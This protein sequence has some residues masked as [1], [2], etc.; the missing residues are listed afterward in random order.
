MLFDQIKS[1]LVTAMRARDALVT[2]VLRTLLSELNY[3]KI[4]VQRE[5]NDEDAV[6]VLLKEA[7]K[8]REA[9]DSYTAGGRGEQAVQE[10]NELAI[11]QKYLPAQMTA[12][13]VEKEILSIEEI[14]D[15]TEF[16]QVMRVVSTRFK[17]RADGKLVADVVKKWL[18]SK[19]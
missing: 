1:D 11:I 19:Q 9:I 8:R 14:K 10:Q 13:D 3:K 2:L 5:L 17:G 18:V 12:D 7:K 16:G 4:D 15:Q 6:A